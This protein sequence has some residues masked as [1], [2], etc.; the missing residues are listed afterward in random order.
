MVPVELAMVAGEWKYETPLG[1]SRRI[2]LGREGGGRKRG[3]SSS[4][5]LGGSVEVEKGKTGRDIRVLWDLITCRAE[6]N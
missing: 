4:A 5:G 1:T 3:G 2:V 6:E